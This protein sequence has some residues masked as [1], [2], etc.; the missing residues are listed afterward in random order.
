MGDE[1]HKHTT[2]S[3][4]CLSCEAPFSAA[5]EGELCPQCSLPSIGTVLAKEQG[6]ES[7]WRDTRVPSPAVSNSSGDDPL[8]QE[9]EE[10][11]EEMGL[12]LADWVSSSQAFPLSDLP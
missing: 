6:L 5:I 9:Q 12:Q 4:R 1:P 10:D 2:K 8:D 11:K 3:K 7:Q